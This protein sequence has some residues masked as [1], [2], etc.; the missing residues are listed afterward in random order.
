MIFKISVKSKF[1]LWQPL[2]YWLIFL[3]I[4]SLLTEKKSKKIYVFEALIISKH[5]VT[6]NLKKFYLTFS[7]RR[8]LSYGNQSID[9]QSK[10]M[11]WFLYDNGLRHERAKYYLQMISCGKFYTIKFNYF[12]RRPNNTLLCK[13][14]DWFLYDNGLHHER[15]KH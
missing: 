15:V 11:D 1:V 9:L 7:W 5:T 3:F 10:S 14:V 13:P 12:S 4:V 6:V 8:P 2:Y